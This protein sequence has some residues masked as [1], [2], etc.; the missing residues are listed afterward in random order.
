MS[1]KKCIQE[2][3]DCTF[4]CISTGISII[5]W[6][7]LLLIL[8]T[9][10]LSQWQ[11]STQCLVQNEYQSPIN[12]CILGRLIYCQVRSSLNADLHYTGKCSGCWGSLYKFLWYAH[13]HK[14]CNF[15]LQIYIQAV[16][17]KF[18][19][20]LYH[21]IW[22]PFKWPFLKLPVQIYRNIKSSTLAIQCSPT[23]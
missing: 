19:L 2:I 18:V 17:P 13:R 22:D 5:N 15:Y 8:Q 4:F 23:Q 21:L 9:L 10:I 20:P 1:N 14:T 12:A 16:P 11:T 7:N 3:P 6:L